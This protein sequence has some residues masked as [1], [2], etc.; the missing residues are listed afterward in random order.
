[1]FLTKGRDKVNG[2]NSQLLF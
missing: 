2:N 1:M